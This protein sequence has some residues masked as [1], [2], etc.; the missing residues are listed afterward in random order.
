MAIAVDS[1]GSTLINTSVA[2]ANVD[3]TAA[4][5]GA[6]CYALLALGV[7]Q[8][9]NVTWTGWT[10]VLEG[11]EG[12]STHYAL[13]RRV[14][15]SGDT[16]FTVTWPTATKG[17]LGWRSY[18]GQNG[19]TPDEGAAVTLHTT[20]GTTFATPSVTPTSNDR[21]AA[22]FTYA[23]STTTSGETW[24]PD[25][26]LTERLDT[27]NT[28]TNPWCPQEISESGAAV[29]Q[30]A[31]SYTATLSASES[32]GG[33][34]LL[35][36]IPAGG[37]TNYTQT[38]TDSEGLTDSVALDQ[39]KAFS[40]SEGLT[41]SIA[42]D[43]GKVAL[44]NEGLTDS[45]AFDLSKAL[46]ESLGLTDSLTLDLSK[47]TTDTFG[48]TDSVSVVL[49]PGGGVLA[50]LPADTLGLTDSV[51]VTLIPYYT[52]RVKFPTYR[53]R[54]GSGPL[55]SRYSLEHPMSLVKSGGVWR[56]IVSPTQNDMQN[57]EKY[58]IGGYTYD[59]TAAEAA[60]LPPE[61]VMDI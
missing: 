18:T 13:Y 33:A 38:P 27:V 25:A 54:V 10:S 40:D 11:N 2:T 21:W 55:L 52:K 50:Q 56:A 8:G 34:I 17:T 39:G 37:G 14:K 15:Q 51:V 30:A 19:T 36:L 5:V 7:S 42:L 46:A 26:A 35:Y 16:T 45:I 22:T 9:S 12:T 57:A 60:D 43:V 59:L 28:G 41:D 20:A 24:T 6:T 23:R 49:T 1:S 29:T 47:A 53:K 3:I 61:W 32:H 31:H 4:A 58:F 44:D 48:L